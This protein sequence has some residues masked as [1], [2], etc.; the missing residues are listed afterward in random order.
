[1]IQFTKITA[2]NCEMTKR[3]SIGASGQIESSAIAHMTE[4]AANVIEIDSVSQLGAF[5]PLLDANQAITCGIPPAHDCKLTTRAGADFRQDAVARTN[6]VFRFPY[7][8]ALFPIDVDVDS[9]AYASVQDVMDALEACSPWLQH[10][11]RIARPSSSSFVAGRGLRGVHVYLAVTRGTDIPMLKERLQIE[12]WR[13]GRGFIKISKSGALLTR[14]LS[15]D[16]V[17]QPSRLMFEASPVCDVGIVR[18]VPIPQ[19]FVDRPPLIAVGAPVKYKSPEGYLIIDALPG[20]RDIEKRRFE[21]AKRQAKDARRREAKKIAID[22]QIA[23]A[24]AQGLDEKLGERYGLIATRAL[25]DARLPASWEIAVK[26]VGR[27]KVSDILANIDSALGFQCADPFDTWHP[28]LEPKHFTKAEIVRLGDEFGVWSHKMQLF[29]AF[30]AEE[31]ADLSTPLEQAAEK[32]CGLIEYPDP[33]DKKAASELNVAHALNLLFGDADIALTY[34]ESTYSIDASEIPSPLALRYALARVDCVRVGKGTLENAIGDVARANPVDPWRKAVLA[35]PAWDKTVRL[36][37]FWQ[38]VGAIEAVDELQANAMRACAQVLFASIVMRQLAP[39]APCQ[40]VPVLVGGGGIGKSRFV[41]E[42]AASLNAPKPAAIAFGDSIKMSMAASVSIVAELAEMTGLGKRENEEIKSWITD[43]EDVY[44][45]PYERRAEAHPRRFVL[46]GTANKNEVNRD[47]TGNR[48]LQAIDFGTN[49]IDPNWVV[50]AQQLLAE[51]KARFCDDR[52]NYG[53]LMRF[54]A[55]AVRLH[56]DQN[57]KEGIGTVVSD[58]DDLMPPILSQLTRESGLRSVKS[59]MIRQR[60]D[61]TPT[62]KTFS[63]IRVAQ[64]LKMRGW[65]AKT[66]SRGMRAYH[67]PDEWKDIDEEAKT[68]LTLINNPFQEKIG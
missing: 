41:Q 13:A 30:T 50:D 9:A 3:Y 66:D 1:M 33:I 48:R 64:W 20:M 14:Q 35:L 53:A 4:G 18:D 34:N 65:A 68:T 12:Q 49:R 58:L 23:N 28:N 5:L 7:G 40:V 63:A 8:P 31:S 42:L 44:R 47:E 10:V 27:V 2:T 24:T 22:Y 61:T 60:L 55:D 19:M 51:A 45:A 36:D 37:T 38:D 43:S 11:H 39:G 57:M 26:D 46:I 29:F 32:L 6:E 15:D 54:A 59:A 52:E 62:G 21:T 17:Y 25:G 16:L 56:N 67:A